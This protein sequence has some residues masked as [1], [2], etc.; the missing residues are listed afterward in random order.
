ME[1]NTSSGF[2]TQLFLTVALILAV[3]VVAS[4]TVTFAVTRAQAY[5]S[6]GDLA[7]A[8]LG[9][10]TRLAVFPAI[11]GEEN[12]AAV[13][14]FF[15]E[16][17]GQQAIVAVELRTSSGKSW[18]KLGSDEAG[19]SACGFESHKAIVV[20]QQVVRRDGYWCAVGPIRQGAR[21]N[22]RR[23]GAT[24]SVIGEL[25]IVDSV[26][27]TRLVV[28]R[29]AAWNFGAGLSVLVIGVLLAW[30]GVRRLTDPLARLAE[31]MRQLK[32]G[33]IG[34]AHV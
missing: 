11:V 10:Y 12:K 13:D 24:D 23:A 14:R 1:N 18:R 3:V 33:K 28:N 8:Q 22:P 30:R 16:T 20:T 2:R 17:T 26:A 25:R 7:R 9:Q 31:V 21:D 6:V 32:A 5:R 15:D 34:R 4:T 19:I 29:L 27:D